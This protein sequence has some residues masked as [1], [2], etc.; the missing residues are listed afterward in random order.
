[1]SKN[2]SSVAVIGLGKLGLPLAC[3]LAARGSDVWAIDTSPAVVEAVRRRRYLGPEPRIAQ[4]LANHG[5]RIRSSCDYEGIAQTQMAFVLVNT[6]NVGGKFSLQQVLPA[7]RRIA[8]RVSSAGLE[9]YLL[10]IVSTVMPGDCERV[11]QPAVDEVLEGGGRA[12][13]H[14]VHCPEF[15][16]L[17]HVVD[18]MLWPEYLVVGSADDA[19]RQRVAEFYRTVVRNR[20]AIHL[21]SLVNAEITKLALNVAVSFKITCANLLGQVCQA[22]PGG[23][24][25]QVTQAVGGDSRIGRRYFRGGL[26]YAGPCFPRDVQSL[27]TLCAELALDETITA[28]VE[29]F[30]NSIPGRLKKIV[31]AAKPAPGTVGVLGL[32]FRAGTGIDKDSQAVAIVEALLAAGMAVAVYD[33]QITSATSVLNGRAGLTWCATVAECLSRADTIVVAT[34]DECFRTLPPALCAG[35]TVVD[36]WRQV[37]ATAFQGQAIRYVALGRGAEPAFPHLPAGAAMPGPAVVD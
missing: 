37:D 30:N 5:H 18:N 3:V 13:I 25:D 20:P 6:P 12:R 17:G 19:A 1:M 4:M 29:R 27:R 28:G 7:V 8:R 26:G 36:C 22:I 31:L 35:K 21:M 2:E 33:P 11:I 10:V 16:A 34:E 9:E 32:G 24:V 14:V 23:D 15:V